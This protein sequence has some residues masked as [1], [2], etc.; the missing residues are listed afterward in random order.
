MDALCEKTRSQTSIPGSIDSRNEIIESSVIF[1]EAVNKAWL[2]SSS[3]PPHLPVV[4]VSEGL[5]LRGQRFCNSP[6]P[7]GC[8][9]QL[10]LL[11]RQLVYVLLQLPKLP[12]AASGARLP[13]PYAHMAAIPCW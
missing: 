1:Q 6:L 3:S 12:A 7:L 10:K 8:T 5:V 9:S 13:A 2:P 11:L 4:A